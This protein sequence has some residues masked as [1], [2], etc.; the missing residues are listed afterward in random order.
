MPEQIKQLSTKE[1]MESE[2]HNYFEHLKVPYKDL[3]VLTEDTKELKDVNYF[4]DS[5]CC[6]NKDLQ[7]LLYEV[8]GYSVSTTTKLNKAFILQGCGR[9]G[10]SKVARVIEHLVGEEQ[11]SHLH[12]EDFCGNKAGSKT[13]IRHFERKGS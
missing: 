8:I 4:F 7:N 1:T 3:N 6:G 2:C 5:I 13:M 12:L 11:C 10:K 9:N